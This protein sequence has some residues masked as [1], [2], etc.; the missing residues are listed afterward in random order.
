M[1]GTVRGTSTL[2]RVSTPPTCS[3]SSARP[4]GARGRASWTRPTA[5]MRA[6]RRPVRAATGCGTRQAGHRGCAAPRGGRPQHHHP[7]GVLP[8]RARADPG[9]GDPLRGQRAVGLPGSCRSIRPAAGPSTWACSSTGARR[10]LRTEEP[11][12]WPERRERRRPVPQ[13]PAAQQPDPGPGG[14]RALRGRCV[15][16]DDDHPPGRRPHPVPAVQPGLQPRRGQPPESRRTSHRLLVGSS[17]G[18]AMPGWTSSAASCMWRGRR[19]DH[20]PARRW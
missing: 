18:A 4:R 3:S 15:L 7:A 19:R 20:G 10:H 1:S 11:A 5:A 9:A 8:A 14:H 17:R 13:R 6:G 2:R 12:N 16:G